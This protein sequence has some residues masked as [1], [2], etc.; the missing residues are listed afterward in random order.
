MKIKVYMKEFQYRLFFTIFTIAIN[1]TIIFY[2]KEELIFLLGQ[3]QNTNFPHFITTNLPEIFFC[4]IKI[5]GFLGLYFTFPNILLQCWF[6]LS[7]ALY[8]HEHQLIKNF[9]ILSICLFVIGSFSIY[10]IVLPYSWKFF[11]S[12]ELN[13]ENSGV[14]IHLE[15]RFHEYLNLFIR[16]L[17]TLNIAINFCLFISFL[18]FRFPITTLIKLRKIIYFSCFVLATLITPPDVESQIFIGFL[19]IALYELFMFSLFLTQEYKKGE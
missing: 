9:L 18:L 17:S 7:P 14:S 12:F 2:F 1:T 4:F 11:S 15:T 13:Y 8:R 16:L 6:F 19:L 3:H 10:K 5:S